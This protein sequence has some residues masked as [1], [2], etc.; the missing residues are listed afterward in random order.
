MRTP[1]TAAARSTSRAT[2]AIR[3]S[4]NCSLEV[5]PQS[6]K[7]GE[8]RDPGGL[9][10]QHPRPQAHGYEARVEERRRLLSIE[11]GF[12]TGSEGEVAAARLDRLREAQLGGR[13]QQDLLARTPSVV[14]RRG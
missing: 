1:G 9:G 5:S 8:R 14:A 2:T 7:R 3:S 13:R 6:V 10:A 11:A 12:R 4:R